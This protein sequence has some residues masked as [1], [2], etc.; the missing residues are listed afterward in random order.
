MQ[1]KI[2]LAADDVTSSKAVASKDS[3]S[4]TDI[5][6]AIGGSMAGLVLILGIIAELVHLRRKG[7]RN[8]EQHQDSPK[9]QGDEPGACD[10]A[11]SNNH[12][13]DQVEMPSDSSNSVKY[14]ANRDRLSR[15]QKV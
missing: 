10:N 3:S 11:A 5:G 4:S 15:Q 14:K 7:S 1:I 13:D 6:K 8:S 12:D 9:A 2:L